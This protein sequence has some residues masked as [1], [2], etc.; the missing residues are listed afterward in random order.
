[1]GVALLFSSET[2]PVVTNLA[3]LIASALKTD[4]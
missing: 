4:I 3:A 1:M 2:P